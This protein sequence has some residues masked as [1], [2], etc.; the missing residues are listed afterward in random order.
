MYFDRW[1]SRKI[2]N[3]ASQLGAKLID[4]GAENGEDLFKMSALGEE[5]EIIMELSNE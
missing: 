3:I 1:V 4:T 5:W 2:Y